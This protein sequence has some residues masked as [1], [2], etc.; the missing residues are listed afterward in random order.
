MTHLFEGEPQTAAESGVL[1]GADGCA[2]FLSLQSASAIRDISHSHTV[3]PAPPRHGLY[4]VI[5]DTFYYKLKPSMTCLAHLCR[6]HT[7]A[8]SPFNPTPTCVRHVDERL[9]AKDNIFVV[10]DNLSRV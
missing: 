6:R 3:H 7:R 10:D 8:N 5:P 9:G 1:R 2:L 4:R